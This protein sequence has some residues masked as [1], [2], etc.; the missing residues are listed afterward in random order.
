MDR[1]AAG[2]N[3]RDAREISVEMEER[4]LLNAASCR[5]LKKTR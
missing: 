1:L 4:G 2:R 3:E 5:P